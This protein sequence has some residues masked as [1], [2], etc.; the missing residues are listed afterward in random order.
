M[1]PRDRT[2]E[3]YASALAV[4]ETVIEDRFGYPFRA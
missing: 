2:I 3:T 4:I 1:P